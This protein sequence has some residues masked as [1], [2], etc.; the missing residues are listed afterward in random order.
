MVLSVDAE[1]ALT[2]TGL[3]LLGYG[4]WFVIC[5]G[6]DEGWHTDPNKKRLF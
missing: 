5:G 6:Q 2:G 3:R 4:G 1:N